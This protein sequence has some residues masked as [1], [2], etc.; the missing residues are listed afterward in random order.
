MG[1]K[2][3]A[4][5]ELPP[6]EIVAELEANHMWVNAFSCIHPTDELKIAIGDWVLSELAQSQIGCSLGI[7]PTVLLRVNKS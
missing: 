3:G 6:E 7:S 4:W 2:R 1:A 5:S